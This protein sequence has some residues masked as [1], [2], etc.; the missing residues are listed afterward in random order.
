[1][2]HLGKKSP[3]ASDLTIPPAHLQK[4]RELK[5]TKDNFERWRKHLD[6]N[7]NL[8]LKEALQSMEDFDIR[9]PRMV[10][11]CIDIP[12]TLYRTRVISENSGEDICNIKTFSYPPSAGTFQRASGP[13]YPVFYGAM[14]QKTAM[15]E[16]RINGQQ[17][18]KGDVIFLSEWKVREGVKYS[19]ANFTL[20]EITGEH[21]LSSDLNK[22]LNSE[23][24][25]IF[26]H[27]DECF[28]KAQLY[29]FWESCKLF[30][31]GSYLQS[32]TIAHDALFKTTA[33]GDISIAGILYPSCCNQYRSI[34][35]AF[36]PDFV[37]AYMELVAVKKVTFK[38]FTDEGAFLSESYFTKISDNDIQW[39][40]YQTKI[41]HTQFKMQLDTE[42]QWSGELIDNSTL[43]IHQKLT[44]LHTYCS[45][46]VNEIDLSNYKIP[47]DQRQLY[48]DGSEMLFVKE[49]RFLEGV[50]YLKNGRKKN[51]LKVLRIYIP[52]QFSTPTVDPKKV[53][54]NKSMH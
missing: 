9:I 53:L 29:L 22:Q 31:G 51:K 18:K 2:T 28:K 48:Q 45:E 4:L 25:R 11:P 16:L 3:V 42:S 27:E 49:L 23:M 1:M 37:D 47:E 34:N 10:R 40:S 7:P 32:G 33:V 5:Q 24:H 39:H 35:V 44:D 54:A 26:Q 8:N 19:L 14:D 50:A 36:K 43:Y 46:K 6:L 52:A 21:Q 20:P 41:L 17:I 38:E 15:E 12:M 13:G 30:L